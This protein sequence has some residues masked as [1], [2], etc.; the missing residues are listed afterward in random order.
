M[1]GNSILVGAQKDD[2]GG[3]DAGAVY[4][5]TYNGST[6]SEVD[7]LVA[8]D[9]SADDWLGYTI[10]HQNGLAVISAYL[11]DESLLPDIGSAYA[12][13]DTGAGWAELSKL[14]H[15]DPSF[16]DC[17]GICVCVNDG[18]ILV[19]SRYDDD[20][21]FQSGAFY[22]FT[23]NSEMLTQI[24]PSV[25][26]M[27]DTVSINTCGSAPGNLAGAVLGEVDGVPVF[28]P[29]LFGFA[30]S[31]GFLN[32]SAPITNSNL[33]GEIKIRAL[34]VGGAGGLRSSNDAT[35]TFN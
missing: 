15:S 20:F 3:V 8:S 19:G 34:S 4:A 14:K 26:G 1:D 21:G 17:F 10:S 31:N 11:D 28:Q 16:G 30:D 6:W 9:S 7:K 25:A 18:N 24:N 32:V 2:E 35:L 29:L 13:V 23:V 27:G 22:E 5:F 33:P 12:F